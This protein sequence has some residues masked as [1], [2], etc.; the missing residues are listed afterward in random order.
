M[1]K[2]INKR[3]L[4]TGASGYIGSHILKELKR[5]EYCTIRH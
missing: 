3:I 1:N 4:V 2:N 5:R